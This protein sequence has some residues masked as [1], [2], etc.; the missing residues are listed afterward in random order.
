[1]ATELPSIVAEQT[2]R[3]KARFSTIDEARLRTFIASQPDVHGEADLVEVR[4]LT[5]GAGQSNGIAFVTVLLDRGHGLKLEKF[6]LRYS[7]GIS[8]FKQKCF[9]DEFLTLRAAHRRGLPVPRVY[10]LDAEGEALGMPA[11]IMERIE[12]DAPSSA[13]FSQG[14]IANATPLERKQMMLEAADFHGQLRRAA[15]GPDSV[16]HLALRGTGQT[17]VERE[18]RWWLT[19]AQLARPPED[20][21]RHLVEHEIGWLI[22][23]QPAMY[24]PVLVHGDPQISNVMY[25]DGKFAAMLDWEFSYLGHTETDVACLCL[26]RDTLQ[27]M[28]KRVEGTPSDQ[29][30]LTRYEAA[31][32]SQ[33]QHWEFFQMFILAKTLCVYACLGDVVPSFDLVWNYHRE[34]LDTAK[35]RAQAAT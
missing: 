28:D 32:G 12:G 3:A 19:E 31:S 27:A 4:Y 29:E 24:A 25:R 6:V 17:A 20:P 8:L 34:L 9:Q 26:Q 13:V 2:K 35:K 23:H 21:L 7:P 33:V 22:E 14:P 1:V 30:Y 15:I 10:W 11:Y 16:P 5:D 18:L